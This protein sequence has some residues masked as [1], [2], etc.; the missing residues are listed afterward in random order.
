MNNHSSTFVDKFLR[1]WGQTILR[2]PWLVLLFFIGFCGISLQYTLQH[3]GVNTDTSELLSPDL[4]FQKNRFRWE[5][6][7]PQDST[8]ILFVIQ[9]KTAEHTSIAAQKLQR[10]MF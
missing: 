4:P 9:G 10:N 7:F 8:T 3:L 5:K 2:F 6:E 1:W